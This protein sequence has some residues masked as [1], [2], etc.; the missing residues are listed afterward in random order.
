MR[1]LLDKFR[2]STGLQNF[3]MA[4]PSQ[5]YIQWRTFVL[6]RAFSPQVSAECHRKNY[7]NVS[8]VLLRNKLRRFTSMTDP[9]GLDYVNGIRLWEQATTF[10]LKSAISP[11]LLSVMEFPPCLS[12]SRRQGTY[13]QWGDGTSAE[14]ATHPSQTTSSVLSCPSSLYQLNADQSLPHFHM[15]SCMKLKAIN[16]RQSCPVPLPAVPLFQRWAS[17]EGRD[18]A[19]PGPGCT[20]PRSC[21]GML[22]VQLTLRDMW[23]SSLA[24]SSTGKTSSPRTIQGLPVCKRDMDQ[25]WICVL[26]CPNISLFSM[27]KVWD[28]AEGGRRRV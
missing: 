3:I 15:H 17:T 22:E 9:F 28:E 11:F 18:C 26:K 10:Q 6:T 4:I 12:S 23:A 7:F 1:S 13:A 19:H 20:T 5:F 24:S 16:L 2:S 14:W 25:A 27:P 21:S 8:L